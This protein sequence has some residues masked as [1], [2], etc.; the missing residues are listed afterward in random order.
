[1]KKLLSLL[2]VTVM[3]L[4]TIGSAATIKTASA[5]AGVKDVTMIAARWNLCGFDR[6]GRPLLDG[7]STIYS[8]VTV[9]KTNGRFNYTTTFPNYPTCDFVSGVAFPWQKAGQ[10]MWG[11]TQYFMPDGRKAIING[12]NGSYSMA[13][14][15]NDPDNWKVTPYLW[16]EVWL[17][18][19]AQGGESTLLDKRYVVMD[20]VGQIWIDPDGRFNDCRYW[21][22][23]NPESRNYLSAT[24][25][26]GDGTAQWNNCKTNPFCVVDPSGENNTQGPYIFST[27]YNPMVGGQPSIPWP[28]PAYQERVYYWWY[29]EQQNIDRVWRLGWAN[30]DD[31]IR[32]GGISVDGKTVSSGLVGGPNNTTP[33][34]YYPGKPVI[35]NSTATDPNTQKWTPN[36]INILGYDWDC[37][38]GLVNFGA[39]ER[40]IDLNNNNTYD[41][42]E[43]VFL[44]N[45][46]TNTFTYKDTR[47][48][49]YTIQ[50]GGRAYNFREGTQVDTRDEDLQWLAANPTVVARA[51]P[52]N[53][54]H[55]VIPGVSLYDQIYIDADNN[56]R[57]TPND[58]RLTN[59]NYRFSGFG[60]TNGG[61]WFG[62]TFIMLEVMETTCSWTYNVSVESDMW[63]AMEK[64][65]YQ[66]PEVLPSR[67]AAAFK[68]ING[69]INLMAQLVNKS[70]AVDVDGKTINMPSTTFNDL[71]CEYREFLGLQL[72]LDNGVDNN[73]A[74]GG[75]CYRSLS[76]R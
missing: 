1:M 61:L 74:T 64:D 17:T 29:N 57:I 27:S 21:D 11:R 66:Y 55:A 44:D 51:F 41:Y 35:W 48:V 30:N 49:P 9:N 73:L 5:A 62:D 3:L 19:K 75:S 25:Y 43:W 10:E 13:V 22:P 32:R 52:A 59:I 42:G 37:G 7:R 65:T 67:T 4:A 45:D 54:K 33:G 24:I 34:S 47:L 68:T 58:V 72:F 31:Y 12:A 28:A 14:R 46:T 8:D 16:A 2:V 69:D 50:W 76:C 26:S 70:T 23:A 56:N 36:D 38:V 60:A 20:S 15:Q 6:Y 39:T 18:V 63:M 40:Y 71:R 53:V